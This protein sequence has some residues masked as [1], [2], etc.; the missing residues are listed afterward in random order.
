MKLFLLFLLAVLLAGTP[1]IAKK[2][3]LYVGTYTEGTTNGI[4][5][6]RFNDQ[7]GRLVN[8]KTPAVSNNPSFLTISGNKRFLY[9]V[10]EVD[11]LG[12][13]QSGGV[14]SFSIGEKGQL[15]L[16]NQVLTFGANPC[17]VCLSPDNKMLVASNY[18]GGNISLFHVKP[19]GSLSDLSQR[20]QHEGSGPFPERQTV[21]HAHSSQFDATGKHLYT[22]DL[23]IDEL[24]IYSV[25]EGTAPLKP[26][27]QPYVKMEPGS[28]PR[29]FAF[30]SDGR[31][32]Y[33]INELS[34]TIVVLMKYGAEWKHVQT[35]KT[36][37]KDFTG[38]S[39]C[40]DIHISA[41]GRFVYGSNR[42]HNSISVFKR[43]QNSGK[44]ELIET[45]PVEGNWPRNFAIDPSGRY[46]LVAN[47]KS[48]DITIFK[49]DQP[50]GKL[51]FT[52]FKIPNQ[53]PVCLQ[54]LK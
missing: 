47:Q 32:I 25:G 50:S 34:S 4:F 43:E 15:T 18:T 12:P 33:V 1:A 3:I 40:A 23:G 38:E 26:S 53:S 6:Y 19:D 52:G 27:E 42:G 13:N 22:A 48:N 37:P 14:S 30:S 16:I 36:L 35:I 9:A 28:G 46:L 54:F 10:G 41:N 51:S 11:N 8:L 20:I 31:F 21:P 7:T 39:W 45:V 17:H 24:K 29:H 2:H 44:L 5:V 49:I